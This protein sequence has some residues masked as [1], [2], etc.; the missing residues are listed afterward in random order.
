[1]ET[2]LTEDAGYTLS[3]P[4]FEDLWSRAPM[5]TKFS[6]RDMVNG[7]TRTEVALARAQ[8]ELGLIPIEAARA[9]EETGKSLKFDMEAMRAGVIATLHQLMPFINQFRDACPGESGQYLH[10]GATTQDIIDTGAMLRSKEAMIMILEGLEKLEVIMANLAKREAETVMAGRTHGQQALPIT[11]GFKVANWLSELRRNI[12]RIRAM[13]DRVFVVSIVGAV[14]TSAYMGPKG[15]EVAKLVA[16]EL[17]LGW[18]IV[19]WQAARDRIGE[20]LSVMILTGSSLGRIGHELAVLQKT[21]VS[22]VHEPHGPEQIGSSTMPQKRNPSIAEGILSAGLMLRAQAG[23]AME[24]M[25]TEHERDDSRWQIDSRIVPEVFLLLDGQIGNLTY[26]LE[27][28]EVDRERM[29]SNIVDEMAGEPMM[30]AL[31]NILGRHNAHDI[32]HECFMI[33]HEKRLPILEVLSANETVSKHL[34]REQLKALMD[35]A[36]YLGVA[37]EVAQTEASR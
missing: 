10:W 18:D 1:M 6:D 34:D 17:Q 22:E 14:G 26:L 27:G 16:K 23:L 15:I 11:F 36:S 5:R 25:A 9:I 20:M 28:L 3:S 30:R 8:A 21:E 13:F 4:L 32:L 33:A 24:L 12:D 29:R 2:K 35:P 31:A 37:I 7:W 19:S